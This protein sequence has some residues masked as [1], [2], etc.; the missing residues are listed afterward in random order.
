M[1]LPGL[2][3]EVLDPGIIRIVLMLRRLKFSFAE[4]ITT[5]DT[6]LVRT[7]KRPRTAT[8]RRQRRG[9]PGPL[10]S[11]AICT[12][13]DWESSAAGMKPRNGFR[14]EGL[15]EYNDIFCSPTES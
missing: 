4:K 7:T 1:T 15:T 9:T 8:G 11:L 6:A 5:T 13:T 3:M 14:K 12:G 2:I 10:S